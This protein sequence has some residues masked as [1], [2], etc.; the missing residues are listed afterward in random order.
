MEVK[1]QTQTI[2]FQDREAVIKELGLEDLS[3]E[4]QTEILEIV[5]SALYKKILLR[6]A[7]ELSEE[8]ATELNNMTNKDNYEQEA[9]AFIKEKVP[10]FASI[11][12]EEIKGF[13]EEVIQIAK[14]TIV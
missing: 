13:R 3:S 8:E 10:N 9:I 2:I 1:T 6:V 14:D 12:K 7:D 11:L 5:S 4:Q